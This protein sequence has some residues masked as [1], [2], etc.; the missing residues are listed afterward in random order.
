MGEENI[1][2]ALVYLT[3]I[4][5][6]SYVILLHFHKKMNNKYSSHESKVFSSRKLV[7][8]AA[9]KGGGESKGILSLKEGILEEEEEEGAFFSRSRTA[10]LVCFTLRLFDIFVW[11]NGGR[12]SVCHN[13]NITIGVFVSNIIVDIY[14]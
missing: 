1:I 13:N 3:N 11:P 10:I 5:S 4:R 12:S 8:P 6:K 2:L 14:N 9:R 7:Y